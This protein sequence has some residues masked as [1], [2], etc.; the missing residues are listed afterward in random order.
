MRPFLLL[1]GDDDLLLQRELERQLDQLRSED[2]ELD[3][4]VHDVSETEHLP[5]LRTAS[6]FGGRTCVVLRGVEAMAGDL[7]AEVEA[8]AASPSDDAVLVLVARGAGRIQKVARLAKEADARVEV[9]SPPDWEDR[10]WDRLVGEEFRRL[11]RKA[12]ATAIAAIRAHAGQVPG[13]IASKVASVCAA[14]AG[15]PVLTAEH[16]D[17]VVEGHGRVSGFAVADAVAARDAAGALVALRG[18]LEAGEAPLAVHGAL[19]FRFRQ[20][21]RARSSTSPKDAGLAAGQFK[22]LK[23]TAAAFGPGELAWCHDRLAQLDLDLK[24]SELPG[25]LLLELA[26]LELAT[27]RQVGAPF[28]PLVGRA[29]ER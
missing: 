13:V 19:T 16:V 28:N 6:L 4:A 12:D 26:V 1:V 15:V 3:V 10:S 25:E 18:V 8:Y 5:E 14:N 11:Q 21:L 9:K 7:K 23:A 24:G 17:A 27:P 22:R 20:L 29:V 2:P